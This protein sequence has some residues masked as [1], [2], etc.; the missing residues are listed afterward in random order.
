M[1]D[2]YSMKIPKE[3]AD[4]FE[5]FITK[6]RNLGY[7]TISQYIL[8]VLQDHAKDI[9]RRDFKITEENFRDF[10]EEWKQRNLENKEEKRIRLPEGS[11]T[12]KDMEKLF[13][14]E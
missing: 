4:L 14:E 5:E 8:H 11:Y 9:V 7:R 13:N 10:M 2:Y 1:T 3:L 6:N 12:K